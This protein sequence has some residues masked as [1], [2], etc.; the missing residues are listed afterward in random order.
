MFGGNQLTGGGLFGSKPATTTGGGLFGN[1]Q[2]QQP[3]LQQQQQQPQQP[4]LTAMTRV[5]DLPANIKMNWN[6]L[7][8][9]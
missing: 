1:T 3:Q 8:N 5:G 6:N 7:I 2:Q 4:H 9:I